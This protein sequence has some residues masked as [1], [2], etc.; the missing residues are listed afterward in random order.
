MGVVRLGHEVGIRQ[1]QLEREAALLAV[2]GCEIETRAEIIQD[3]RGLGDY[4]FAML[5]GGRGE[6]AMMPV[7]IAEQIIQFRLALRRA[8]ARHI[9][10]VG[11]AFA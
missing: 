11:R 3:Q 1:G 4:R 2:V 5:E 9:D 10:P 8:L 6:G 7:A